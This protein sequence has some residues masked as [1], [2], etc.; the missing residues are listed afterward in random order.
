MYI[1]NENFCDA[2]CIINGAFGCP[3]LSF[4][5]WS[6][7]LLLLFCCL[8]LLLLKLNVLYNVHDDD[9]KQTKQH[10]WTDRDTLTDDRLCFTQ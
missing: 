5:E 4:T 6:F 3:S 10:T 1:M 7:F 8:P 2:F 9:F